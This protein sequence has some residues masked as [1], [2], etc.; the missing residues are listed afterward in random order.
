MEIAIVKK[1]ELNDCWSALQYTDNCDKCDKLYTCKVK[2]KF[3]KNGIIKAYK[4]RKAALDKEYKSRLSSM[5]KQKQEF[6]LNYNNLKS[7][8]CIKV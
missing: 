3:H 1:S 5:K 2:S 7:T 4:K 6:L 8:K